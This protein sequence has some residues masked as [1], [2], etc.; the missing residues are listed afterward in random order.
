M[1]HTLSPH[2]VF[3]M[4]QYSSADPGT[5]GHGTLPRI[6]ANGRTGQTLLAYVIG[7]VLRSQV[8]WPE[9]LK[10]CHNSH[11]KSMGGIEAPKSGTF[12]RAAFHVPPNSGHRHLHQPMELG[13]CVLHF[14]FHTKIP[15][16][17]VTVV[18]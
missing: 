1:T 16:R 3:S 6:T 14:K 17:S 2:H 9:A 8:P 15:T 5:I 10:L 12:S 7:Y 18:I 11:S 4:G 13:P